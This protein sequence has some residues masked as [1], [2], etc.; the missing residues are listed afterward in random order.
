MLLPGDTCMQKLEKTLSNRTDKPV[1][2][3]ESQSRMVE[4]LLD[5]GADM[6]IYILGEKNLLKRFPAA[7]KV[8]GVY[9]NIHGFGNGSNKAD[10]YNIPDFV[11]KSDKN[12]DYIKFINLYIACLEKPNIKY[13][14]I[15]G[16]SVFSKMV[17]TI[18]RQKQQLIIA[19][20]RNIYST[21]YRYRSTDLSDVLKM[22][23][24]AR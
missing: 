4:C 1:F 22:Y 19:H 9:A 16:A 18:D 15:L 11:I 12:S 14:V 3:I 6:S 10:I 20:D 23:S 17:Y 2:M 13:E 8:E 7:E 24:F 5:T 21:G